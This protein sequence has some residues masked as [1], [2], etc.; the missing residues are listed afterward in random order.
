MKR[1]GHQR[2]REK[3]Q[4]SGKDNKTGGTATTAKSNPPP[5]NSRGARHQTSQA[6]VKV[7]ADGG[8]KRIRS[9]KNQNTRRER[10]GKNQARIWI[11]GEGG[12]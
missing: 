7:A 12:N 1:T 2:K 3:A 9:Q 6:K 8:E 4:A 5:A 10:N 11:F